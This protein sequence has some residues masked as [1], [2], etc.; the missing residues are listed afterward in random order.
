M[1]VLKALTFY[2]DVYKSIKLALWF[3]VREEM[4]NRYG[5]VYYN[6]CSFPYWKNWNTG[7]GYC[8]VRNETRV[9]EDIESEYGF[10]FGKKWETGSGRYWER[11][12]FPLL[13]EMK[14]GYGKILRA[15]MVPTFNSTEKAHTF[16]I[17]D[18]ILRIRPKTVRYVTKVSPFDVELI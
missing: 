13:E 17:Y 18:C 2:K 11:I 16:T 3:P 5:T 8:T 7:T 10:L 15:N 6:V 4:K 14:N 1:I 12:W 9:L